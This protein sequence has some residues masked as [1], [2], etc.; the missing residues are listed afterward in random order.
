M[1]LPDNSTLVSGATG[2][3]VAVTLYDMV[4]LSI[5]LGIVSTVRHFVGRKPNPS[6]S[7]WWYVPK[8]VGMVFVLLSVVEIFRGGFIV[9]GFGSSIFLVVTIPAALGGLYWGYRV[10]WKPLYRQVA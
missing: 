2:Y 5:L 7:G 9:S 4:I 1:Q 6:P 3:R 8:I 10:I